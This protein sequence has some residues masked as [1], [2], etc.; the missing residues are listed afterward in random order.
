ME[1][2]A[3]TLLVV[4]LVVGVRGPLVDFSVLEPLEDR[5]GGLGGFVAV[6]AHRIFAGE[7]GQPVGVAFFV[8]VAYD[9]VPNSVLGEEDRAAERFHLD[10]LDDFALEASP[11][12][13]IDDVAVLSAVMVGS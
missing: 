2:G 9:S 3:L 1:S 6:E 8:A 7:I 5:L 10:Q 4:G 11:L 13:Q 12:A